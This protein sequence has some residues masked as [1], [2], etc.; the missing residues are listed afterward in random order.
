MEF[1]NPVS[2]NWAEKTGREKV[3]LV[4]H[5]KSAGKSGMAHGKEQASLWIL[6]TTQNR[7]TGEKTKTLVR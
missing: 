5:G 4:E 1:M 6:N 7:K 3:N 2:G